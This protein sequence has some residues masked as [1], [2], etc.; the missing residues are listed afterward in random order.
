[1]TVSGLKLCAPRHSWSADEL[2]IISPGA[3]ITS[4]RNTLGASLT[5]PEVYWSACA[6]EGGRATRRRIWQGGNLGVDM[7]LKHC[8]VRVRSITYSSYTGITLTKF[9]RAASF[10]FAGQ[11]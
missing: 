7:D 6:L 9:D 5:K 1:M 11:V 8:N 2:S 10:C 3:T 4:K